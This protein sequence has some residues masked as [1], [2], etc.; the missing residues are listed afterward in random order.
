MTTMVCSGDQPKPGTQFRSG[1]G[2][3]GS[4]PALGSKPREQEARRP[5][6][7]A[8]GAAIATHFPGYRL[9]RAEYAEGMDYY[10]Q[11]VSEFA[12]TGESAEQQVHFICTGD[13]DGN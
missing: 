3:A 9:P 6:G 2:A 8:P 5:S 7:C 10:A 4:R 13:F 12:W 1:A 11:H